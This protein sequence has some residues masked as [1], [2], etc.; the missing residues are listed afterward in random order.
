MLDATGYAQNPRK[1]IRT[2]QF[3][4]RSV[5]DMV[6]KL[7]LPQHLYKTA[8]CRVCSISNEKLARTVYL[9]IKMMSRVAQ[10][11]TETY[12]GIGN[13]LLHSYQTASR[14]REQ[15]ANGKIG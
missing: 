7:V 12:C 14:A 1:F 15:R 6:E 2:V 4:S 5:V 10:P 11:E 3:M 13:R 9:S 8:P